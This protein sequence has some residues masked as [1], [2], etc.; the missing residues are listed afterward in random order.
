MS[1]I[2]L[3][4]RGPGDYTIQLAERSEG[5]VFNKTVGIV[6]RPRNGEKWAAAASGGVTLINTRREALQLLAGELRELADAID[7]GLK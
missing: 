2:T 3:V 5:E 6:Y 4:N 7:G 1:R